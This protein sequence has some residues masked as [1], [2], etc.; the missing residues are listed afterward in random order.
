MSNSRPSRKYIILEPLLLA[1]MMVIG[2]T[3][4]YKIND[5]ED[6]FS[7]ITRLD[8]QAVPI[9]R[10]EEVLR[11]VENKYVDSIDVDQ[12]EN[13]LIE[14]ILQDLDPHSIYIPPSDLTEVNRQMSGKFKG[15]GIETLLIQ[16]TFH[17]S[18]VIENGPASKAGLEVGMQIL[19]INDSIVSGKEMVYE[20]LRALI[21]QEEEI[22]LSATANNSKKEFK[23]SPQEFATNAAENHFKIDKKTGYIYLE[24][25][26][27]KSYNDFMKAL[28]TLVQEN[29]LE[30]LIIDLRDNPGGYLPETSKILSQLFKERDRLLLYTEGEKSEK[31]EYKT[32]GKCFFDIG[33]IAVLINEGSA[34]GS[35]IL[36]GAI[37]DW[38][39]GVI[40]GSRSF[41]KGLVQEQ[42]EL[43]NG[44]AIRLTVAKYYTP[45]GRLIQKAYKGVDYDYSAEADNRFYNGD[46][47]RPGMSQD[48]SSSDYKTM[49]LKRSVHGGGGVEPDVYAIDDKSTTSQEYLELRAE[50][51][52]NLFKSLLDSGLNSF[53]ISNENQIDALKEKTKFLLNQAG[54]PAYLFKK[55]EVQMDQD[56]EILLAKWTQSKKAAKKVES[57]FDPVIDAAM[58]ALQDKGK[59]SRFVY[60]SPNE[61]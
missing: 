30:N 42:Y 49:I 47:Y 31:L 48:S 7:L 1:I 21:S 41:G 24:R 33:N 60:L 25:F 23:L 12:V 39:R 46:K 11:F 57:G 17:I 50:M 2:I 55:Y 4:G 26:T 37:Q 18:Y 28:E 36:A 22:T 44:G 13:K 27:S 61:F 10:I 54:K 56:I 35:E 52:E 38:D 19:A 51:E 5:T 59:L 40:V 29:K 58:K 43:D 6:D 3:I 32:T 16:D 15:I 34:S 53:D 45:S 9:G 14:G 8:E 20:E